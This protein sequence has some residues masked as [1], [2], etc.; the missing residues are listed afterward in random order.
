M[1]VRYK[2]LRWGNIKNDRS[3]ILYSNVRKILENQV[4]EPLR[5]QSVQLCE[6]S[7]RGKIRA[8]FL[9]SLITNNETQFHVRLLARSPTVNPFGS[10]C[11][12]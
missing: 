6:S 2:H 1:K 11:W 4:L 3:N 12:Q 7:F 10:Y 9:V 8:L 5:V